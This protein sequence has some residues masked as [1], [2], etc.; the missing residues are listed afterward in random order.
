MNNKNKSSNDRLLKLLLS[1]LLLLCYYGLSSRVWA[2]EWPKESFPQ[3]IIS[4]H[5]TENEEHEAQKRIHI[6]S[7]YK[8]GIE[9]FAEYHIYVGQMACVKLRRQ[10]FWAHFSYKK[11]ISCLAVHKT[12]FKLNGIINWVTGLIMQMTS[13][14]T[15]PTNL[16]NSRS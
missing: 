10:F 7:K 9:S 8:N 6:I 16:N 4:I 2:I 14:M 11:K 5:R 1:L 15:C 13:H 3:H 12:K